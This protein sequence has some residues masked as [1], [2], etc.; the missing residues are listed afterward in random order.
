[1]LYVAMV[2]RLIIGVTFA[3]AVL[4]K[5]RSRA[6]FSSFTVSLAVLDRL[7][8]R[9]RPVVAAAAVAAELTIVAL[10][11]WP[12]TVVAGLALAAAAL[13]VFTAVMI[14]AGRRGLPVTC[15]CF[16]GGEESWGR[17]QLIRNIVLGVVA[18]LGVIALGTAPDAPVSPGAT[19]VTA[20]AGVVAALLLVH[21]GDLAYLLRPVPARKPV[22]R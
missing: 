6:A 16:G 9:S 18:L 1:M 2:C 12:P 20:V 11:A 19:G 22:R 13:V 5:V 8:V 4:G 17:V 10:V 7:P 14:H 15:R 21:A 3:A